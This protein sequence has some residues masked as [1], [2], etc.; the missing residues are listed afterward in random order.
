[1][2]P[3]MGWLCQWHA[4]PYVLC[5]RG[6]DARRR[7]AR[8]YFPPCPVLLVARASGGFG[9]TTIVV[10][11]GFYALFVAWPHLLCNH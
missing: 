1:M 2:H 9:D 11:L 10:V 4:S 8:C 5:S 7:L 6:R 3:S